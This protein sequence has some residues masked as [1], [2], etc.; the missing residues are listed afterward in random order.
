MT[1]EIARPQDGNTTVQTLRQAMQDFVDERNWSKFH[2]PKNLAGSVSIEAAELLE[3]FQWMT[4]E[5]AQTRAHEDLE[6]RGKIGDEMADVLLYL[7]SMANALKIDVTEVT[8]AKIKKNN[9][10]YPAPLAEQFHP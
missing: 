5:E 10:K 3:L 2:T 1:G 6:L 9:L 8:L 4:T 7:L